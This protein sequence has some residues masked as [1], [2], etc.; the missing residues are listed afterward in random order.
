L[1]VPERRAQ[2]TVVGDFNPNGEINRADNTSDW[3]G[4]LAGAYLFPY[5]VTVGVN[6]DHQSGDAFARQVLLE[7]GATIPDITVNAE[8]IGTRR[9]PTLNLLTLRVE[10]SFRFRTAQ[11]VAVRFDVYNALNVNA[12][13]RLRAVSGSRFLRPTEI[14][15]PRVAEF[16]LTYSF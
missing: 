9:I 2:A 1:R 16:G 5:D 3:Q 11:R 4:K 14:V 10:K 15:P 13:T 6:F 12:A 7:G 8:P